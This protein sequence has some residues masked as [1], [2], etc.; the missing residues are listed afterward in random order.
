[1]KCLTRAIKTMV[2][3]TWFHW[4]VPRKQP[5]YEALL[6]LSDNNSIL[7][8]LLL[9][10]SDIENLEAP[11]YTTVFYLH[12]FM[13]HQTNPI[14]IQVFHLPR[15]R[16][17][18]LKFPKFDNNA[19]AADF[20]SWLLNFSGG[21]KDPE[22]LYIVPKAMR[23][24]NPL[25]LGR[26]LQ[27]V[28]WPRLK[29]LYLA[30]CETDGLQ[31]FITAHSNLE[32]VYID[33]DPQQ[34]PALDWTD[35][36]HNL[37]ALYVAQERSYRPQGQRHRPLRDISELNMSTIEYLATF[38]LSDEGDDV[39]SL[40]RMRFLRFLHVECCCPSDGLLTRFRG[41]TQDRVAVLQQLVMST[42]RLRSEHRT[43]ESM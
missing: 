32:Y 42:Y 34:T 1:M 23:Q 40:I 13:R 25:P 36:F 24:E 37:K 14:L 21:C 11:I 31:E 20:I 8:D 33:F 35:G 9:K 5:P 29:R 16:K 30:F 10:I 43:S 3:L 19:F 4:D 26:I 2:N 28:R 18:S 22:D 15:L 27:Q 41:N 12:N 39:S 38:D 6:Y 17:F 7:E